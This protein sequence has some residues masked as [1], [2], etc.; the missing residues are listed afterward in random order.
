[1]SKP[2]SEEALALVQRFEGL[3]ELIGPGLLKSYFCP[4]G[5]WTI[6]WGSTRLQGRPVT[7]E[8]RCT[9][10]E[11]KAQLMIDLKNAGIAVQSLVSVELS[12]SQLSALASLVYNIG[13][14]NFQRSTLL[15]RLNNKE[16]VAKVMTEE[17]PRWVKG[18][19]GT[20]LPGLVS[21]RQ[22]ELAL[23]NSGSS[24]D[25]LRAEP[26]IRLSDAAKYDKGLARQNE[27]WRYLF[28]KA[29]K[30]AWDAMQDQL[31]VNIVEQFG[32]LFRGEQESA[33]ATGQ[34]SSSKLLSVIYYSQRDNY[35]DADRTC[36][37]S[38]CAMALKHLKPNAIKS[39]DDYIR[40][41]FSLG[42]TT[43]AAVQVRALTSFGVDAVFRQNANFD[44]IRAQIDAGKTV[45]FG[46]VH[47]GPIERPTGSGHWAL[48]IGY[49]ETGLVV[50]DPWG[51]PDLI[52]GATIS[53]KGQSL[54]YSYKNL[55]RRWMVESIGSNA[56]RYAP[57]KGW[58][59][60][61]K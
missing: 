61:L 35:R 27:A 55:G 4:A 33:S 32:Q 29:P 43:D 45:P 51:E 58:C 18:Q 54:Q 31:P 20:V 11:A 5:V 42:D 44:L 56:F 12:N 14:G 9:I 23:L 19:G 47:R 59:L 6:G 2:I 8:T 36:F 40:K 60:A 30:E 53:S 37:S 25:H 28:E 24:V 22:A 1:M 13:I 57:N 49:T 50:H 21:R 15:R 46:W 48:A 10:E 39:D 52:S 16:P 3:H 7:P 34:A 26:M 41:V 17:F 38:T